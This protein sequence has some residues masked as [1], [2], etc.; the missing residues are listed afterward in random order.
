MYQYSF[1]PYVYQIYSVKFIQIK[2]M[3]PFVLTFCS[4]S[5]VYEIYSRYLCHNNSF[6]Y[7][8]T[9]PV[10]VYN[11]IYSFYLE[12]QLGHSLLFAYY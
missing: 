8:D 10:Y 12:I 9:I 5:N 11:I 4:P 2:Y 6:S 7:L 1:F 3:S